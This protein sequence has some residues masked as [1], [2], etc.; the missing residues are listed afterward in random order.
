[1]GN[2]IIIM[3]LLHVYPT[4]IRPSLSNRVEGLNLILASHL[5]M[6][7]SDLKDEKEENYEGLDD[8]CHPKTI[9]NYTD[10][11]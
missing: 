2:A 9:I 6:I 7:L 3:A 8:S 4:C 10:F 1:M 5:G 11:F